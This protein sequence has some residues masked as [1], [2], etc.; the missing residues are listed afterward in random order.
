MRPVRILH[1]A[2]VHL[3]AS[4]AAFGERAQAH[5]QQLRATF[6]RL[7]EEALQGY[8]LLV[9]AGDLFDSPR[10]AQRTVDFV[11]AQLRGLGEASPPVHAAILPGTHDRL[12]GDSVYERGELD[13]VGPHLHLMAQPGPQRVDLPHLGLALHGT[14]C[15]AATS[16]TNPL[17]GLPLAG[18]DALDLGLAHASVG[19]V[20][21]MGDET[22]RIPPGAIAESGLCYL[23]L[24]HWH[25][26]GDHSEGATTAYYS[27][28]P[29]PLALD[30]RGAGS[31]AA[32]TINQQDQVSVEQLQIGQ[33]RVEQVD[34]DL[35]QYP[36]QAA[37]ADKLRSLADEHLVLD[38]KLHGL[39]RPDRPVDADQLQEELQGAF[40]R[41]H[42]RDESHVALDAIAER[43]Y[44]EEL[45]IGRF[46]RKLKRAITE[47][48]AAGDQEAR[49]RAEEALQIGVALLQGRKVL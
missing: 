41:L 32:V 28:A 10:P 38:A 27:G 30:Q 12:G 7:V 19:A 17:A 49:R 20:G 42:L 35:A 25:A 34:I 6:Q 46:V 45:V 1:T 21:A 3:G 9:I 18:D 31:A 23:A 43:D 48:E 13:S 24:G 47:A 8:D 44:P 11:A 40:F 29:E 26:F 33:L 5:R 2:D 14:P 16:E 36:D 15:A 22:W 39:G 4:A 37:I